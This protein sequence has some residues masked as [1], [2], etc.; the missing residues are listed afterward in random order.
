MI[1]D[2]DTPEIGTDIS[3]PSLIYT[4]SFSSAAK[5]ILGNESG[6]VSYIFYTVD[7]YNISQTNTVWGTLEPGYGPTWRI[8]VGDN[9]PPRYEL[10]G[11][12]VT[13][14]ELK[15]FVENAFLYANTEVKEKALAAFNDPNG[16]FIDGELYIFAE[17]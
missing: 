3:I 6:Q 9:V 14:E 11:L 13:P 12:T 2:E 10:T 8:V 16:D 15:A 7:W 5:D 4:P 17:T 1:F